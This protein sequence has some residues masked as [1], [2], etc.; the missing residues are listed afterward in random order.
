ML[1]SILYAIVC[2]LLDR[3]AIRSRR[4]VHHDR[5]RC[6]DNSPFVAVP[7]QWT[8]GAVCG[9]PVVCRSTHLRHRLVTSRQRRVGRRPV[10]GA[11]GSLALFG[12][13]GGGQTFAFRRQTH[14]CPHCCGNVLGGPP[15]FRLGSSCIRRTRARPRALYGLPERCLN[16][17]T[18]AL[19]AELLHHRFD[20]LIVGA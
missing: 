17:T 18:S 15:T 16:P 20:H 7:R 2:L 14:Q 5:R 4:D 3:V 9:L 1:I 19:E 10:F 6:M 11:V 12:R 8:S 13:F